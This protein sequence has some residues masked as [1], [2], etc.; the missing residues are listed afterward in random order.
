MG[1]NSLRVC[2]RERESFYPPNFI[3]PTLLSAVIEEVPFLMSLQLFSDCSQ[4]FANL[5]SRWK[6]IIHTVRPMCILVKVSR[7]IDAAGIS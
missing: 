2:V 7:G 4:H 3:T 6:S 5:I 1:D